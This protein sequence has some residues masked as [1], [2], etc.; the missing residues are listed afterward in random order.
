VKQKL[1]TKTRLDSILLTPVGIKL[2][3]LNLGE[4]YV[5]MVV[6]MPS[7]KNVFQNTIRSTF[8][9]LKMEMNSSGTCVTKWN[10]SRAAGLA[11]KNGSWRKKVITI[12]IMMMMMMM[13]I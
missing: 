3:H 8:L 6:T 13:M 10:R 5:V 9:F 2:S 7:M 11:M 12:N 4:A 1:F